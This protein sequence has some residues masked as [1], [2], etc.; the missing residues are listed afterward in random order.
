MQ[1][2]NPMSIL[3]THEVFNVPPQIGDQDLWAND[4]ALRH[5]VGHF[6]ADWA[7]PAL[8]E[9]GRE[10]GFETTFT[11]SEQ[12]NRHGPELRAFDR[13]GMRLNAVEFLAAVFVED[14]DAID[15]DTRPGDRPRGGG[16]V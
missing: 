2:R 7:E 4:Q 3:P 8:A 16:V 15:D 1:H 6:G 13:N 10:A 12:A 5:W 11:L 9:L 14:A